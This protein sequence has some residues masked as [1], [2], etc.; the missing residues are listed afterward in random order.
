MNKELQ[1]K[2]KMLMDKDTFISDLQ[3]KL[4]SQ[5]VMIRELQERLSRYERD[6]EKAKVEKA[7][8]LEAIEM[9]KTEME[10]FDKIC[11]NSKYMIEKLQKQVEE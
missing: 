2:D 3:A 1:L 11:G 9:C 5:S 10:S 6:I 4:N 8:L 7:Q